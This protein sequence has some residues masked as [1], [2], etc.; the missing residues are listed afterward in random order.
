VTGEKGMG[1]PRLLNTITRKT[2][3]VIKVNLDEAKTPSSI[4]L[5]KNWQIHLPD[6][7]I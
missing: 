4:T 7:S 2:A 3:G 6:L 1:N 5:F